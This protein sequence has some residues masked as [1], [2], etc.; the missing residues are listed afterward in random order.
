MAQF[1]LS[2]FDRLLLSTE[3][4]A[5]SPLAEELTQTLREILVGLLILMLDTGQSGS[6]TSDPPNDATGVLTDTGAAYSIDEHNGRTL[7]MTSGT[8]K[9]LIYTIDDTTATTIVCTGDNLYSDG[10][11]SADTYKIIYDLKV[12]LDGHDHD[13]VNS[14]QFVGTINQS[15]LKTSQ[16][17]ISQGNAWALEALPGGEYG[18]FPQLKLSVVDANGQV[19]L[20]D[21]PSS[22][23]Q[24]PTTYGTR[25]CWTSGHATP[26]I[27][28]QQRY[29]TSSGE[30]FWIFI[31]RDK[32]TKKALSMYQ[33][34]DH[35]CMGNG[36]KPLLV[37]HPFGNYDKA[38]YEI[39]VINPTDEELKIMR[40]KTVVQD[41]EYDIKALL[42]Y[43]KDDTELSF[44]Y[45]GYYDDP[46]DVVVSMTRKEI[47]LLY[48][49]K[50][51]DAKTKFWISYPNKDLLEV[52]LEKYEIDESSNPKWPIKEVTVGLPPDWNEA[53]LSQ[54][55][56]TPI[57]KI[58]PKPDYIL[59]RKLKKKEG[60][61]L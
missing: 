23:V 28:A 20:Y 27:Y 4:D 51:I 60:V 12:N 13:G 42:D 59:C 54:T 43:I 36:G 24:M 6:A 37:P 8:A 5:D 40:A 21:G 15:A 1:A 52:I 30:V 50:K 39:I 46:E 22:S 38:K 7:L 16:G 61:V 48:E 45:P 10:V 57:K 29:V 11:R 49:K 41:S 53:W 26:T 19:Y 14:K 44:E 25:L 31:L 9:G 17:S 47:I 32:I 34:P 58:I 18:F 3:D 56:I 2:N 33:A 35:P 55:P